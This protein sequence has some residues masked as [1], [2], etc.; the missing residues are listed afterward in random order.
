[1]FLIEDQ[2][3]WPKTKT[4]GL[5]LNTNSNKLYDLIELVVGDQ[6]YMKK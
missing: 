5:M 4:H 3:S 2:N 6:I 1:M